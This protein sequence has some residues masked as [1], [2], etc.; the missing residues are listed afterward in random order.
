MFTIFFEAAFFLFSDF[1]TIKRMTLLYLV[2]CF[3]FQYMLQ[4]SITQEA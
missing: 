2:G 4:K 1:I 3:T